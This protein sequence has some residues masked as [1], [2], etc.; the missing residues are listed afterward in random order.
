MF[1]CKPRNFFSTLFGSKSSNSLSSYGKRYPLIL[2]E[3]LTHNVRRYRF[4]LESE[5]AVL[6]L[7]VGKHVMVTSPNSQRAYTPTTNDLHKGYFDLIVKT[8]FPAGDRPGGE[9]SM[10]LENLKVGE[11]VEISGPFGEL[12]YKGGGVFEIEEYGEPRRVEKHNAIGMIAGGTGIT[13][14]YQIAQWVA[15]H[16]DEDRLDMRL[17]FGNV[18]P[19]DVMMKADLEEL[20]K[21]LKEGQLQMHFTVDEGADDKWPHQVGLISKEMLQSSL[22]SPEGNPLIL[23]C[24][25]PAMNQACLEWLHELGHNNIFVY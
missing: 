21:T 14:M 17:V 12:E 25:P 24:G 8:Y 5:D 22:P 2:R 6:G 7:P 9:I 13:P 23:L 11:Q 4:K 18:S 20:Q 19:S 1:C 3:D 10:F 16:P 15:Q